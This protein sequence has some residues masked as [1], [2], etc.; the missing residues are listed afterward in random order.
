MQ[1]YEFESAVCEMVAILS[2]P[3][4][5]NNA[6]VDSLYIQDLNLVITV[7]GDVLAPSGARSSADTVFNEN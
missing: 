7:P 3:L 4:C 1:G 2:Q 6:S 5:V